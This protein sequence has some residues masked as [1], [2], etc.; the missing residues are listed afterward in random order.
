MNPLNPIEYVL[1]TLKY[2]SKHTEIKPVSRKEYEAFCKEYVFLKLKGISFGLAF[3]DKF[4][5]DHF[6]IR[7]LPNDSAKGYIEKHGFVK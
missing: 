3:C 4:N 2:S 5:I 7:S 6:I 1:Q